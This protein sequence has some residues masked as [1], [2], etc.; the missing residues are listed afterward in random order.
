MTATVTHIFANCDSN[1]GSK[2]VQVR[3][4]NGD[5]PVVITAWTD[6]TSTASP[7]DDHSDGNGTY[8]KANGC[9]KNSSMDTM[10]VWVRDHL[11]GSDQRG[12]HV[13]HNPGTS[14]G[15]IVD[16][17]VI[18][19][20]SKSGST[21]IRS[22]GVQSNQSNSIPAPIMNN[23]ALSTNPVIT[24]AFSF[25]FP[26]TLTPPSSYNDATGLIGY[27]QPNTDYRSAFVSSGET[28]NTITWNANCGGDFCSMAIEFDAS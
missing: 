9:V 1:S 28:S 11:F 13:T 26:G 8:T 6:N 10:N 20:M 25:N 27:L 12:V 19:S 2:S 24:A 15:G 18:K 23:A 16:L 7:T 17:Y 14:S 22:S 21:A 3:A 4:F 5:L